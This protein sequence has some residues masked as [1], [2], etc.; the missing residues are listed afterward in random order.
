M[1]CCVLIGT[2]KEIAHVLNSFGTD[3]DGGDDECTCDEDCNDEQ[4]TDLAKEGKSVERESA[5]SKVSVEA[6]EKIAAAMRLRWKRWR[7]QKRVSEAA[8]YLNLKTDEQV[9]DALRQRAREIMANKLV[10]KL[11]KANPAKTKANERLANHNHKWT[12]DE[13]N[14]LLENFGKM[15]TKDIAVALRRTRFAVDTRHSMLKL[16]HV[17]PSKVV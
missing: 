1:K 4:E 16:G 15:R 5:K 11:V 2:D 13:D 7:A 17:K 14:Y 9:T 12:A 10:K 3:E 8:A 6:R